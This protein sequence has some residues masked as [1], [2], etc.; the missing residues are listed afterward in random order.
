MK[1]RV[2]TFYVN[3]TKTALKNVDVIRRQMANIGNQI[4]LEA[5]V[6]VNFKARNGGWPFLILSRERIVLPN[7]RCSGCIA[8]G[9]GGLEAEVVLG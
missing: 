3:W 1:R 4:N 2:F 7:G 8:I 5:H 6:A 9:V